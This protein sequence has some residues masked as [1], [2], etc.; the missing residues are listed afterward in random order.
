MPSQEITFYYADMKFIRNLNTHSLVLS[1]RLECSGVILAHCNL[2][3]WCSS[4]CPTSAS[5]VAGTTGAC[6]PAWEIFVFFVETGFHHISQSGLKLLGSSVRRVSSSHFLHIIRANEQLTEWEKIFVIYPTDKGLISRIYKK[7]TNLQEKKK[8]TPPKISKILKLECKTQCYH[9]RKER[10][11]SVKEVCPMARKLR[12]HVPYGFIFKT[13][14][15]ILSPYLGITVFHRHWFLFVCLFEAELISV[16]QAVMP[17]WD[18]S[19]LQPLPPRFKQSSCFSL[20]IPKPTGVPH[21]A[22]LIFIFLGEMRFSPVSQAALQCSLSL[23]GSNMSLLV[24][25]VTGCCQNND[26][27]RSPMNWRKPLTKTMINSDTAAVQRDREG[28]SEAH[29]TSIARLIGW[30]KVGSIP[31]LQ[32]LQPEAQLPAFLSGSRSELG[33]VL[34]GILEALGQSL[35]LSPRPECN[36]MILAHCNLCLQVQVILLPEPP[37]YL[38]HHVGQVGLKLLTSSAP[39]ALASQMAGITGLSH[40]AQPRLKITL[41]KI[42]SRSVTQAGMQW[43]D[44]GSLKP[45]PPG[46]RDSC[47]SASRVAGTTDT[48]HYALQFACL[49]LLRSWDYKHLP[50][51]PAYF[52]ISLETGFPHAGQAGLKL[53][54]SSDPPTSAIQSAGITG[55]NLCTQPADVKLL[56]DKNQLHVDENSDIEMHVKDLKTFVSYNI[57]AL[58]YNGTILAHCNLCLLDSTHC[59]LDVLDSSDPL[60]SAFQVAKTTVTCHHTCLIFRRDLALLRR[61][62]SN[63]QAPDVLRASASQSAGIP[64]M[65]HCTRLHSSFAVTQAGVQ[66][67]ILGSLQPLP[68][69]LTQF[70]CFSL[71]SSGITGILH[72][73]RI[74]F[75]FLVETGFRHVDQAGIEL[76]TSSDLP[77]SASQSARITDGVSLLLPRLECCG[78]ISAHGNLHLL[79][80]SNSPASASQMESLS[81]TETGMQWCDLGSLQPLPPGFKGFSCLSLLR[82]GTAGTCHRDWLIFVFL[83]ETGFCHVGQVSLKLLTSISLLS[84]RLECSTMI[85]AHCNLHLPGPSDS[86][87]S[88]FHIAGITGVYHHT[89]LILCVFSRVVVSLWC[90]GLSRTPDLQGSSRLS[91]H[92]VRVTAWSLAL[93][94]KL[95]CSGA[96]SAHCNLHLL[97]SSNSPVSATRLAGITGAHHH[98]QLIFVFFSRDGISLC[99][100]G[101]SRTPE[102]VIQTPWPP[103]MLG[104][105]ATTPDQPLLLNMSVMEFHSCHQAGVQ[106][107][108]LGSLLQMPP[109]RF[110]RFSCLSLPSGWDYRCPPPRPANFCIFSRDGVSPVCQAGLDLLTSTLEEGKAL[111][112]RSCWKRRDSCLIPVKVIRHCRPGGK[113]FLSHAACCSSSRKQDP[114]ALAFQTAAAMPRGDGL[115]SECKCRGRMADGGRDAIRAVSTAFTQAYPSDCQP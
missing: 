63:S 17:W 16:S 27:L 56:N 85:L 3:L 20:L 97:G 58:E 52:C 2:R 54:T 64:G 4:D 5:Q 38:F 8:T 43:R 45:L 34:L 11:L 60:T 61:L 110:K 33:L 79:G 42:Q 49:N 15:I 12:D 109:P 73:A 94:P 69:R 68:S 78:A 7:L 9:Q 81:V 37:E 30:S 77:T 10:L 91:L 93:S 75:L 40:S 99:W 55:V 102:L 92:S 39:L 89:W 83:V 101:G 74:T 32:P 90:P 46:S 67:R 57:L 14:S 35:T 50:P 105:Q 104:L 70:F 76:L 13:F 41:Y 72:H 6:H 29:F 59:N 107:C 19:S 98:T 66:W 48:H 31:Q 21:H 103:K 87:A 80:S 62:I 96:I 36:G 88:A 1:P 53:L 82:A 23:H 111:Q 108:D 114:A 18:L 44:L 51:H 113:S 47:A 22:Q 86:P 100:P 26:F 25:Y 65:S 106:W 24:G 112:T 84:P 115:E 28:E 71:P 95:E